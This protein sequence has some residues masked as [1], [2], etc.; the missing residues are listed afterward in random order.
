MPIT[1][2][3]FQLTDTPALLA[4]ARQRSAATLRDHPRFVALQRW[5]AAA[6]A[7]TSASQDEE[8]SRH[9]ATQR[10]TVVWETNAG[11]LVAYALVPASTTTLVVAMHPQA[12][13]E[14]LLPEA[15]TW[16]YEHLRQEGRFPFVQCRCHEDNTALRT[17]LEQ[18]GY[19]A[20]PWQ[21]V[22]LTAS[23]A[24]ALPV[25]VVPVGFHL[26]SGV[27]PA[28]YAAYQQLHR[29][30]FE[31]MSMSMVEHTTSAYHPELDLI[32]IAPDGVWAAFC[33]CTLDQG[34]D[35]QGDLLIGDVGVMGVHPSF[36][37]RGLGRALLLTAMQRTQRQGARLL[38]LE[39]ENIASP[40]MQ[41]Y[42]ALGFQPGS[43][44]RWWRK[45]I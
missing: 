22:Y 13:Q 42:Q 38:A 33:F 35:Q 31:G 25:P 21:D 40:P 29:D 24:V 9:L 19:Q 45:P 1:A 20:Q 8:A 11:A 2:R 10:A 18:T 44:W 41:L 37:R 23:L 27:T 16:G 17:A 30:V 32:A 7:S 5:F 3:P 36:R 43:P 4:L 12:P 26:R 14:D 28:G 34:A 6:V 39:T 15:L